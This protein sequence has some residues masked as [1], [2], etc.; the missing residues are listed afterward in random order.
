MLLGRHSV[1][2]LPPQQIVH[3]HG[4]VEIFNSSYNL[5][6][7]FDLY[8]IHGC[9]NTSI[10]IYI[11]IATRTCTYKRISYVVHIIIIRI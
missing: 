10:C 5:T 7:K 1:Y 11:H 2:A 6:S 4:N 8:S 3:D 9:I